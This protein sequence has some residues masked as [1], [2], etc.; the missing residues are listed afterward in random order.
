[1]EELPIEAAMAGSIAYQVC[2]VVNVALQ[3]D[4][5]G[6]IPIEQFLQIRNT[7]RAPGAGYDRGASTFTENNYAT[8]EHGLEDV[9]D[10]RDAKRYQSYFD[11]ELHAAR[12]TRL[13]VL[14]AAE[15]RVSDL[16]MNA[17]TF[18]SQTTSLNAALTSY[19]TSDP[20]AAVETSVQNIYNRT[21]LWANTLILGRQNFRHLRQNDKVID[22]VASSGAGSS[23]RVADIGV[24]QLSAVFDLP[25]ILV[26][27]MSTNTANRGL[28]ASISA[29][30][31]SSYMMVAYIDPSGDH[32]AP[33]LGRTFHWDE[34]G[35]ELLGAVETYREDNK[36]STIVRVRHD[37]HEKLEYPELGELIDNAA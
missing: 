28:A 17:T 2:P 36:R 19:A 34:D 22:R 10:D 16:M 5:Y 31:P 8:K 33:T 14:L 25:N 35:S 9:V 21:G 32:Q 3:A 6:R 18:T 37:T 20:L 13:Q 23:A 11:A 26:G 24:E 4:T 1:M 7:K 29:M 27:G 30:W 15:K 12:R